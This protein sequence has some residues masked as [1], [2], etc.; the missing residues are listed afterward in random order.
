MKPIGDNFEE[1]RQ[2]GPMYFMC[3][4]GDGEEI[5]Y[6]EIAQA[7]RVKGG[8][9]ADAW[10]PVSRDLMNTL[11]GK[12]VDPAAYT[13]LSGAM[14]TNSLYYSNAPGQLVYAFTT[15]P[16]IV[17]V[18]YIDE[19]S[20]FYM[21]PPL[22]W[23]LMEADI[24]LFVMNSKGLVAT[25]RTP[26]P[27]LDQ[28]DGNLC[29]GSAKRKLFRSM[30]FEQAQEEAQTIIYGSKFSHNWN[31]FHRA[32]YSAHRAQSLKESVKADHDR[33]FTKKEVFAQPL[34][35]LNRIL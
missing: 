10:R 14:P 19:R 11:I 31:D 1:S 28:D 15:A 32:M 26:F 30:T 16:K 34:N 8:F 4:Y 3:W 24:H 7:K 2:L 9:D 5:R 6:A 29:F 22:M 18:P 20:G 33:F 21:V 17:Y 35:V 23:V 12:S 25:K 27:N 13:G